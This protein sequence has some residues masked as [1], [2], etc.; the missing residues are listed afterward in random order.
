ML[1]A[2]KVSVVRGG[3]V[4]LDQV[5]LIVDGGSRIGILGRNG[6]GKSTLLRVLAGLEEPTDGAVELS[7]PR[8]TVGY[9]PQE[10]DDLP[11]ETVA[12]FLRRR[13]GL[14]AAEVVME[15]TLAV[16]RE[17]PDL[18]ELAA[19]DDA[20]ARFLALGGDDHEARAPRVLAE[21]G[22]VPDRV[23]DLSAASLSG[24]ERVKLGLAAVLLARFDVLL[25]DE[26]TNNLDFAGLDRL[27]RFLVG[28]RAA[29]RPGGGASGGVVLV[30][31]D[32]A[33]LSAATTRVAELDLVSHRL[34]E[35]GGG[36][37][38]HVEERRRRREQAYARY[39]DAQR[40]RSRLE[41]SIRRRKEWS[42]SRRGMRM[43]DN[44]KALA[45]RRN[46]RATAAA[47]GARALERRIERL[48]SPSTSPGG[49]GSPSPG[50]TAPERPPCCA[51]SPESSRPTP[52]SPA[53]AP[54][55]SSATSA[56]SVAP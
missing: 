26:P 19:Y 31:H 46:E 49:T 35:Y 27:E 47:S 30:S 51:C 1:A 16:A 37:D 5:D 15:S 22:L 48:G 39:E 14:A 44:D 24:G 41:A 32:R 21:V 4:V 6:A 34:S 33:F 11:G 20:L 7:P 56:R 36:Y 9:L 25:L 17:H 18:A 3:Q 29:V 55:W 13:T 10:P 2:R 28:E 38:V 52:A 42:V 8:L 45:G 53:S 23:L 40:E 12:A 54:V 43:T 50:R